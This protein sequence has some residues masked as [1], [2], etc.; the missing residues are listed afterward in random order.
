MKHYGF[1]FTDYEIAI[2][3]TCVDCFIEYIDEYGYEVG[4]GQMECLRNL[5]GLFKYPAT[6]YL[7]HASADSLPVIFE[8]QEE[9]K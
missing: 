2:L 7:G 6:K 4:E 5:R 8:P 1:W 3:Y 9:E